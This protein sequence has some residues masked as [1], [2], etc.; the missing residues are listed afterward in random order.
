MN[1]IPG[2]TATSLLPMAAAA[3]GIDFAELCCRLLGLARLRNGAAV[4][5]D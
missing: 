4:A 3:E 5:R 2:M 1:T